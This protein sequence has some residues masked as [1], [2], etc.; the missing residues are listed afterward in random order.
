MRYVESFI[1]RVAMYEGGLVTFIMG[2]GAGST[3][4][5][6]FSM[7]V[8]VAAIMAILLAAI[9]TIDEA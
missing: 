4:I 7:G 9:H 1:S 5:T 2:S 6:K 8:W 3:V